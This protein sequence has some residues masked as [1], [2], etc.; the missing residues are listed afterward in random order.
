ML[1]RLQRAIRGLKMTD[2]RPFRE[3]LAFQIVRL[4]IER[5][6]EECSKF[7]EKDKKSSL[8]GNGNPVA[9]THWSRRYTHPRGRNGAWIVRVDRRGRNG[10][11]HQVCL[12]SQDCQLWM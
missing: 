9:A 12:K 7:E 11:F 3:K 6:F 10:R 5:I 4:K 2:R 8:R 1:R